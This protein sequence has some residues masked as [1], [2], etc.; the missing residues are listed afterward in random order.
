MPRG[1]LTKDQL[2]V[3]ILQQKNKLNYEHCSEEC[4]SFANK[5]FNQIL[6]RLEEFRIQE[7]QMIGPKKKPQDFG[8]KSGDTHIIVNDI[9][10]KAK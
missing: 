8:F 7:K 6:D 1:Q 3:L 5:H 10:E 4:K 2:K 9:S